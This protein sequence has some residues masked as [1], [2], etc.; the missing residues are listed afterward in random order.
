MVT[1]DNKQV[2][3]FKNGIFGD[4]RVVM[5][6]GEPWFIGKDVASALGYTDTFGALKK[7]VEAEDKQ[8]CQNGSFESN[9]GLTSSMKVVF[10]PLSCLASSQLQKPSNAG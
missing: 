2:Q 8:N 5:R 3:V 9:R 4:V 6:D 1:M 7:H 10:I